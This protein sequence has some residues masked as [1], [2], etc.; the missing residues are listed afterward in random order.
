MSLETQTVLPVDQNWYSRFEAYAS[1]Q[2]YDYFEGDKTKREQEKRKFFS[3]EIQNPTFDYPKLDDEKLKILEEQLLQLKKDVLQHES[4]EDVKW[5]YRWRINEKLAE[6]RLMRAAAVGDMRNFH[7]FSEFVYGKPSSEVFIAT[8]QS[9]RKL[10][11]D[12][13]NND[14]RGITDAANNFLDK[15]PTYPQGPSQL[16]PPAG[17]ET[18][19]FRQQTLEKFAKLINVPADKE[20]FTAPEIKEVF[21]NALQILQADGW[22]VVIYE[23]NGSSVSVNQEKK[24][25]MIPSTKTITADRLRA[26]IV[27]EIGTHIVRREEGEHSRLLLLGLGLDRYESGEEGVATS[28]GDVMTLPVKNFSGLDGHLAI[29]LAY[30]LDGVKRDFRSVFDI[31]VSYFTLIELQTGKEKDMAIKEARDRAWNR[32]VRTFRGTDCKTSG[33]AFTKD[34]IY[35]EG[36]IG[37]WDVIRHN[38]EEV[39]NFNVGKYDPTNLRHLYLLMRFGI[40]DSELQPSP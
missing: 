1:F 16:T 11:T 38:P 10:A 29:S 3:G 6:I 35:R 37:V 5:A 14:K 17:E 19:K 32:C 20:T 18:L 31:L 15:L 24:E 13:L 39:V 26:L 4:N 22:R 33:T 12:A 21:E 9:L 7:R 25:V 30:G 2:A 40:T 8:L 27:H 36:S 23:S 34:I 28:R